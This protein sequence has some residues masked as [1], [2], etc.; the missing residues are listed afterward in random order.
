M[1]LS[2]LTLTLTLTLIPALTLT[3]TLT[4]TPT[5]TL[6]LTLTITLTL[7]LTRI[8]RPELVNFLG[9]YELK[10]RS[11]ADIMGLATH[12]GIC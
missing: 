3:L 11:F 9:H 12:L 6:T 7:T 8:G 10:D 4:L 1:W 5:L 2:C